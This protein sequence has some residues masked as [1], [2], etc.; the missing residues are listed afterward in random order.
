MT[1]ELLENN[2]FKF[3]AEILFV[4]EA[5]NIS[6]A[7]ATVLFLTKKTDEK[8]QSKRMSYSLT[9]PKLIKTSWMEPSSVNLPRAV[10]S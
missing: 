9:V 10:G 5:K 7:L 1:K 6:I 3:D 2:P 4:F 8:S